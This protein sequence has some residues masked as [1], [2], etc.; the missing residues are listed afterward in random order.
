MAVIQNSVNKR[1]YSASQR[2]TGATVSL[3]PGPNTTLIVPKNSR[4]PVPS[5]SNF[6]ASVTGYIQPQYKWSIRFGTEGSFIEQVGQTANPFVYQTGEAFYTAFGNTNTVLQ[7]K[8]EVTETAGVGTFGVNA[9][10]DI[11]SIPVIREGND[12]TGL[13][14]VMLTLY[15]RTTSSIPPVVDTTGMAT[16]SFNTIAIVGQPTGWT[17]S[18][19]SAT[20]G[21][22]LWSITAP[23]VS[24]INSYSFLNSLW[25]APSLV[26]QD[27][28][29]GTNSAL[30]YAYKRSAT[31]VTDSPGQ[32]TYSF[33]TNSISNT[34]LANG[35][36]KTIPEG[37]DPLYVTTASAASKETSVNIEQTQ[38]AAPVVLAAGGMTVATVNLYKRNNSTT[39][40]GVFPTT[41]TSTYTFLD[42]SLSGTIPAGWTQLLPN[43]S[44]GRVL[45]IVQATA[46]STASTDTIQNSEWS[47]PRVVA[48]DGVDGTVGT[49][50]A[51][52]YAYKRSATPVTDSPG[53]I[54][55]S[56]VTNSIVNTTLANNWLKAIPEGLDPLY[57]S[58]ASAASKETSVNVLSAQW[59]SPVILATS[60][61]T[62]ATVYLYKRN[63][64]A[65]NPGV[66]PTTG[67]TTYTFLN[68]TLTGTIPAGWTQILPDISQGSVLW[69]TQATAASAASIDTILN[70]EWSEPRVIS[71]GSSRGVRT[72]Y[73]NSTTYTS[74]AGFTYLTFPAGAQSYAAKATDLIAQAALVEN[75]LPT[76]PLTGDQVTFTNGVSFVYTIV[77]NSSTSSWETPDTVIDG[78]L[79]ITGSVTAAK[80]NS[81]GLSIRDTN[82]NIILSAGV[83]LTSTYLDTS[84]T[85]S[86]SAAQSTASSAQT[87]ANN[88][89]IAAGSAI[90]AANTAQTTATNAASAASN[91]QTSAD[92]KLSKASADTLSATISVNAVTGAGFRAGDLTWN[93]S[94]VRTAGK[95]V[96]MTPGGLMCHNGSRTTF[97][98]NAATGD[99]TFGG[100]AQS[101]DGKFIID[102]V[103]KTI[104]IT[105]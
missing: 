85:N 105:V 4:I 33:V 7:V 49:N 90:T 92:G 37:I 63:N 103:N 55:Y 56:F 36:Q 42:G 22:Y 60:G 99:A 16:Y 59:T 47:T 88:A 28:I 74:I 21:S 94:G 66:F 87:S 76:T 25:S 19:P 35:W 84:I 40:P 61:M 69:V 6:T 23:A 34:V 82:G 65:N 79:L 86:I 70:T 15:K 48:Q 97:N 13:N 62:V 38:W 67:S 73:D 27:G 32:I 53:D 14:S 80:I 31:L 44:Q 11:L 30:I 1:L 71:T 58:T 81:N 20:Q 5:I 8:V 83:P 3:S 101:A 39:D 57:V 100:V 75:M 91:A 9:S 46:S 95:G 78:S 50:T 77:Y 18:M 17:L 68:G 10:S 72:L 54:S 2:V 51:L 93:A 43:I 24:Y 26:V 102:F 89:Q 96:A 41:G 29:I 98:L 45:W 52:L 12:G 104:S 64:N